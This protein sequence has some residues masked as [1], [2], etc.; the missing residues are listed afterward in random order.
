MEPP[1]GRRCLGPTRCAPQLPHT[2]RHV[3]PLR[4]S[5]TTGPGEATSRAIE[6]STSGTHTPPKSPDSPGKKHTRRCPELDAQR[7]TRRAV[8]ENDGLRCGLAVAAGY[9]VTSALILGLLTIGFHVLGAEG[10]FAGEDYRVSNEWIGLT[11][12]LSW[13]AATAG[14]YLCAVVDSRP[15]AWVALAVWTTAV[16]SLAA[17]MQPQA[18]LPATRDAAMEGALSFFQAAVQPLWV[19]LGATGLGV[20]GV[21]VGGLLRE[22][23]LFKRWPPETLEG[24]LISEID[25]DPTDHDH[26]AEARDRG[27]FSSKRSTLLETLA[28]DFGAPEPDAAPTDVEAARGPTGHGAHANPPDEGDRTAVPP[29]SS[30]R[31]RP[32]QP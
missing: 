29:A 25:T 12:V 5:T 1:I 21:L 20:C 3:M 18:L 19:E 27:L 22:R 14:G 7:P 26:D 30:L 28:R 2:D 16:G 17:F 6:L 8:L 15:R 4:L 32:Q 23:Q 9:G 10:A 11:L 13:A 24:A 31:A